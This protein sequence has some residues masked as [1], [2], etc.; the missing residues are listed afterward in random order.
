MTPAARL[1]RGLASILACTGLAAAQAATFTVTS[2]ADSGA[3]TLRAAVTS[4][5]ASPGSD[6]I[7]F[8]LAG[9]PCTITLNSTITIS[10][11]LDVIGPGRNVLVVTAANSVRPF[12]AGLATIR[13][14]GLRFDGTDNLFDGGVI[15]STGVVDLLDVAFTGNAGRDGGAVRAQFATI[16]DSLFEDNSAINGGALWLLAGGIIQNT[17]FRSNISAGPAIGGG[18][19]YIG[20]GSS[21]FT[22]TGSTFTG[23]TSSENGGA[24]YGGLDSQ[25]SISQSTFTGNSAQRWGGAIIALGGMEL[26]GGT[27][28]ANVAGLRG[29]AVYTVPT[30]PVRITETIFE[31][32]QAG[33]HGGAVYGTP[34][35]VNILDASRSIFRNNVA[36]TVTA[37]GQGGAF[38]SAS[39]G[40]RV[41][42]SLLAG[43]TAA[44][45]QGLAVW[46]GGTPL[47]L[48][49]V[50]I[51]NG[52]S[53][54]AGSAITAATTPIDFANSV[55]A[56]HATALTLAAGSAAPDRVLVWNTG[57]P[58]PAFVAQGAATIDTSLVTTGD[59][60]FVNAAGGDYH[61]GVGSAAVN[62]SPT[63]REASDYDGDSRPQGAGHDAGFDE[64]APGA[65]S[66]TFAP[67]ADRPVNDAPFAV[68]AT[69]SSGLAV[70]FSSST[71]SVCTVSGATV[72]LLAV[73][74]CTVAANQAGD[75]FWAAAAPVARTFAVNKLAQSITFAALADRTLGDAPFG[76]T[77]TASSGLAVTFSSTTTPVCTVSGAT[78]RA[79]RQR[80]QSITFAAA[81]DPAGRRRTPASSAAHSR[82]DAVSRCRAPP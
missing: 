14:Q 31:A 38:Y 34:A 67:L 68:S 35:G 70:T 62:L 42:N 73:G 79:R 39:G 24:I 82:P 25:M 71:P 29:G 16:T 28:S 15:F 57:G 40:L 30:R 6:V 49:H 17:E 10:D 36:G 11:T 43:N 58:A 5:N 76:L 52:G 54:L 21:S 78:V 64:R 18:A 77:A 61:L 33:Q 50:T 59:P 32:N 9:C 8:N 45:G 74:N 44:S 27:L 53:T 4:A 81:A 41:R 22:V 7:D 65:Q 23:N 51:A 20:D 26:V 72:T 47:S 37:T 80:S 1:A 69:A 13:F 19:V 2:T 63:A 56:D 66:I 46:G 60:V 3:G 12:T 55:V 48:I 75:V